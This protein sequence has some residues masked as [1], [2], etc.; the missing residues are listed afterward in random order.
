MDTFLQYSINKGEPGF[1]R[2]YP[3]VVKSVSLNSYKRENGKV[4]TIF[5][6][7]HKLLYINALT[8]T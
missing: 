5:T 4:L 1:I 7:Q 8:R 6:T 3:L 2:I